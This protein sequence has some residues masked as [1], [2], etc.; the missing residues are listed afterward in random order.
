MVPIITHGYRPGAGLTIPDGIAPGTQS[1]GL[2]GILTGHR[3]DLTMRFATDTV[4]VMHHPSMVL[5]E[6]HP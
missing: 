3:T 2:H 6:Q 4:S 1:G 5:T